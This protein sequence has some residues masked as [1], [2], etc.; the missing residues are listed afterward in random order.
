[1][2]SM[3]KGR[4]LY[5]SGPDCSV[6]RDLK[7]KLNDVALSEFPD[8]EWVEID[9]ALQPDVAALHSVFTVPVVEIEIEEKTYLRF[10]RQISVSD[11][12]EKT[13]RLYDMLSD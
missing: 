2:Y 8:F 4:I 5:F 13:R 3:S 10:V 7:P 11:F 12:T 9:C 6:C 1:M